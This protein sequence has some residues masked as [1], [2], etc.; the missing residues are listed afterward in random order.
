MITTYGSPRWFIK[1]WMRDPG[2]RVLTRG[3]GRLLRP[4]AR[5]VYL[6][7]YNMDRATASSRTSFVAKVERTLQRL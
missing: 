4:R 2:K 1:M 6:A 5:H 3:L 7:R